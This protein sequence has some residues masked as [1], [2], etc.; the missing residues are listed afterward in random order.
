MERLLTIWCWVVGNPETIGNAILFVGVCGGLWGLWIAT[1]RWRLANKDLLR[2]RCQLG[3]ELLSLNP[4]H[5]SARAG[6][7]SILSDIL[8]DD[9]SAEYDRA[10]L[11]VFEATL[12]SPS[13]FGGCVGE[14]QKG[15][16][17]YES[18]ETYLVVN[19]MRKYKKKQGSLPFLP[20]PSGLVFTITEN[21]VVPN[22]DHSHYQLWLKAEGRPP[23]YS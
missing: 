9:G 6:G 11:R 15:E 13:V 10:I 4:A 16:V 17:D 8:L 19:A 12:Y 21:T 23:E 3:I 5:Y 7:A 1:G 14:H 22:Q 18:R 2:Q 20:I